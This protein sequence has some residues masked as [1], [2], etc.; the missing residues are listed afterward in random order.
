[1]VKNGFWRIC[2]RAAQTCDFVANALENVNWFCLTSP[3]HAH[4]KKYIDRNTLF[5][6]TYLE[7]IGPTFVKK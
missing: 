2:L 7:C 6:S 1:M 3:T 4:C 5:K